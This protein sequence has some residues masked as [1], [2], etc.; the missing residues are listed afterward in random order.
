M[1][2]PARQIAPSKSPPGE[3]VP[4]NPPLESCLPWWIV[5][6]K[7]EFAILQ[8][9]YILVLSVTLSPL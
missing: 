3:L 6:S 5:P 1:W 7:I 4:V 9:P 2:I 8:F